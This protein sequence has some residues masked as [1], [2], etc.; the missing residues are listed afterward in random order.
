[1]ANY[2]SESI[3]PSEEEGK[4]KLTPNSVYKAIVSYNKKRLVFRLAVCSE[5]LILSAMML[6]ALSCSSPFNDAWTLGLKI[7]CVSVSVLIPSV[8]FLCF[9]LENKSIAKG[10]YTLIND[11]VERV[12]RS[13][14]WVYKWT[15]CGVRHLPE[16]AMYLEKTRRV[17][18]PE[19][20]LDTY[21][22][23]DM[24]YLIVRKKRPNRP[25]VIYNSK[26]YELADTEE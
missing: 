6:L 2:V 25:L 12:V 11:K 24:L 19:N 1:M 7:V 22:E 16:N 9:F 4:R 15:I 3:N 23:D 14:R 21:S 20:D 5:F 17:V 26:Y 8:C 18:I 13:D 10:K